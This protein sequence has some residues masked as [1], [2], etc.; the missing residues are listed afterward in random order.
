MFPVGVFLLSFVCADF[1]VLTGLAVA[2]WVSRRLRGDGIFWLNICVSVQLLIRCFASREEQ[3]VF[4]KLKKVFNLFRVSFIFLLYI[5]F[6][7][8]FVYCFMS[9]KIE[10]FVFSCVG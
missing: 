6:N 2:I 10:K 3:H 4:S 5:L 9:I 1:L 7:M 8:F